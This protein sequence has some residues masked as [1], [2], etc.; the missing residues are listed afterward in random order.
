MSA[1]SPAA[2][3][4]P[5]AP[6][7][8]K[9]TPSLGERFVGRAHVRRVASRE[10][11]FDHPNFRDNGRTVD[12]PFLNLVTHLQQKHGRCFASVGGLRKMICQDTGMMPGVGTLEEADNRL[13]AQ[14][15]MYTQWLRAGQTLPDGVTVTHGTA[16]RWV[17]QTLRQQRTV[18]EAYEK[19][20]RRGDYPTR[21]SAL[22]FKMAMRK[23]QQIALKPAPPPWTGS[24]ELTEERQPEDFEGRRQEQLERLAAW[25]REQ[26]ADKPP[27]EA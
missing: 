16:L 22:S 7:K 1:A 17:P 14:G 23:L 27:T 25:K 8:A 5:S 13:A 3:L 4:R 24:R 10:R 21:L 6:E 11:V 15:L 12:Q 19:Q 2:T 18:A 26:G 20:D 9:G